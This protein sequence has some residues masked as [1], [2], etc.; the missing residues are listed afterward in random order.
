MKNCC[1]GSS[2]SFS[3][4]AL[5]AAR[6]SMHRQGFW[7]GCLCIGKAS[8]CAVTSW[9]RE[10]VRVWDLKNLLHYCVEGSACPCCC[11]S[12][13]TRHSCPLLSFLSTS[14]FNNPCSFCLGGSIMPFYFE[15]H[16]ARAQQVVGIQ[17]Y[18][19][20]CCCQQSGAFF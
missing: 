5:L 7:R 18:S 8:L 20:R 12:Y 14:R 15:R 17:L 2:A 19:W 1:F 11:Q 3:T 16:I 13:W 6:L 4:Y 10:K 9:L